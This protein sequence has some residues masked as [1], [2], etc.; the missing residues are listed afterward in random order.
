MTS[1]KLSTGKA[2]RAKHPQYSC[3]Y[4]SRIKILS[5]QNQKER[6]ST[7]QEYA[8]KRKALMASPFIQLERTI[9]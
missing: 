2:R 9:K 1:M 7:Q 8:E 5:I 3:N 4:I 6:K